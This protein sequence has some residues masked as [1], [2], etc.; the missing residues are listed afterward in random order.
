MSDKTRVYKATFDVRS[1][2]TSL[3][4]LQKAITDVDAKAKNIL[5]NSAPGIAKAATTLRAALKT[6]KS[7]MN[8]I[9][10]GL[11]KT[12]AQ[13]LKLRAELEKGYTGK[14]VKGISARV[15][16]ALE[17]EK[18]AR[19]KLTSAM[20]SY[21]RVAKEGGKL[22]TR[23][24]KE[25]ERATRQ[26]AREEE[27]LAR[28]TAQAQ[29]R[30]K[31]MFLGIGQNSQSGLGTLIRYATGAS[32][33]LIGLHKAIGLIGNAK[34]RFLRFDD[35]TTATLTMA[36]AGDQAFSYGTKGA[37]KYRDAIRDAAKELRVSA[38]DMSLS[39][40][41][42]ARA[43][44]TN[45][46]TIS[47]LSKVGTLFAKA[48]RDQAGN[49]LDQAAANDI[50]S[51]A[52]QLFQK[53][54]STSVKAQAEATKLA[55]KMTAAANASNHSIEQLWEFTKKTGPLA[56]AGDISEK[57]VM[58][59]AG[60]L[61]SAGLKAEE[62]GR[63]VRRIL[64]QFSRESVQKELSKN[65]VA[66]EDEQ[67]Q[68]RSFGDIF[69]D[70]GKVLKKQK[71]L[72][73]LGFLKKIVGQNAISVAAALAG[74]NEQGEESGSSIENLLKKIDEAEGIIQRNREE[75]LKTFKGRSDALAADISN[76]F[77]EM[78]EESKLFQDIFTGLEKLVPRAVEWIGSAGETLRDVLLPAVKDTYANIKEFLSPAVDVLSNL[79][80]GSA[81]NA[82]E[83]ARILTTIIKL[84]IKWKVILLGIRGLKMVD[85]FIS[86][87]AQM[88]AATVA[89]KAL[90]T[91]TAGMGAA[92]QQGVSA[93]TQAA[94]KLPLAF[95][96]VGAAIASAIVAWGLSDLLYDHVV[97]P[98]LNA[99]NTLE[100]IRAMS[101]DETKDQSIETLLEQ[102]ALVEKD[103]KLGHEQQVGS[104][105]YAVPGSIASTEEQRKQQSDLDKINAAIQS[106]M[107]NEFGVGT[108]DEL[109][110]SFAAKDREERERNQ[111]SMAP[112][113]AVPEQSI[114]VDQAYQDYLSAQGQDSVGA[115]RSAL[116]TY[117]NSLENAV[118][119]AS[120]DIDAAKLEQATLIENFIGADAA[121]RDIWLKM[122]REQAG[123]IKDATK[124][125]E[126]LVQQLKDV[127]TDAQ[128]S[129]DKKK[130]QDSVDKRNKKA[131]RGGGRSRE[132]DPY[133]TPVLTG[134]DAKGNRRVHLGLKQGN[135]ATVLNESP[136][137]RDMIRK[138]LTKRSDVTSVNFGD[139]NIT[140]TA[141]SNAKPEDI[142][143]VVNKVIRR[144]GKEQ[145][146]EVERRIGT[147][148][149]R[150]I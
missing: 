103:I 29:R 15:R 136:Q 113:W 73:R 108:I 32:V 111:Q 107:S 87:V 83:L 131:F 45:I 144:V 26:A 19:E 76:R 125:Q 4:K 34:D 61:A 2:I 91:A 132:I 38:D 60:S 93:A 30:L 10:D 101:V 129:E 1:A 37:E 36:K 14:G 50:L 51:D 120:N 98:T 145:A 52:L 102:K 8:G 114:S 140:I 33:A 24:S 110:M 135:A 57:E 88:R 115:L 3:T 66:L 75:Q 5:K 71:P 127:R 126:D 43:G 95:T 53:D 46:K 147:K 104:A 77:G 64:T 78:F 62:P 85:W 141:N 94:G 23:A 148:T 70:L 138:S 118:D 25:T 130:Q 35:L 67:G 109:S 86:L 27:K 139:N 40:L 119:D 133:A 18:A 96:A 22:A 150:H 137:I 6:P 84:W 105:L 122:I 74:L 89:T 143:R 48:N 39:A 81:T 9:T 116:Q 146:R 90:G 99:A 20:K 13:A 17:E 124:T 149:P 21:N 54:T 142:A 97:K 55:D 69:G 63:L 121:D 59:I 12:T 44:Q 68:I 79:F 49:V 41:F 92:T 123:V 112:V 31:K 28:R 42:W 80:G 82:K 7:S 47:E 65:G 58:A 11:R 106:K 56:V 72:A 117:T 128:K 134:L 100:N 16:R